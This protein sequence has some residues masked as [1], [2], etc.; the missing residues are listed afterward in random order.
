MPS[1]AVRATDGALPC[2]VPAAVPGASVFAGCARPGGRRS[3][4]PTSC[5]STAIRGAPGWM[6]CSASRTTRA[7][8][9]RPGR[10]VRTP[11]GRRAAAGLAG[12]QA[13]AG[14]GCRAV[15]WPQPAATIESGR[16]STSCSMPA[17]GRVRPLWWICRGIPDR[18][19]DRVLEQADLAVLVTPADVR[20]CWAAER[21]CAG[22]VE[23]GTRAGVV[24][25]G[26]SPGGSGRRRTRRCAAACRC[27]PACGRIRRCPRDLESV[28]RWS[29]VGSAT[30]EGGGAVVA[31]VD[32]SHD[33]G[34][35]GSLRSR[36]GPPFG[37][38]AGPAVP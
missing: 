10:A 12:G 23:F 14:S 2:S 27:W 1:P 15:P 9:G 35:T 26:P 28:W 4:P 36:C 19:A 32:R 6:S 38:A 16:R 31:A 33:G 30:V 34:H 8:L 17:G 7:A 37:A 11:A 13:R 5:W 22:S 21:V 25:R 18:S 29:P 20:G 24:V 3:R